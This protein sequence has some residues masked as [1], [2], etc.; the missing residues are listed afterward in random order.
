MK[1]QRSLPQS[2]CLSDASTVRNSPSE[3]PS[4][5][6]KMSFGGCLF[7]CTNT[8][9]SSYQ[10][11]LVR[12]QWTS[13]YC[14]YEWD[15]LN[16]ASYSS[17]ISTL[18]D[19]TL[20]EATYRHAFS[21]KDAT[22][23]ATEGI[24]LPGPG[25]LTSAPVRLRISMIWRAVFSPLPITM[26][27]CMAASLKTGDSTWKFSPPILG[28]ILSDWIRLLL[29]RWNKTY[30]RIRLFWYWLSRLWPTLFLRLLL[31]RYMTRKLWSHSRV[32][33]ITYNTLRG[34]PLCYVSEPLDLAILL[35]CW[36]WKYSKYKCGIVLPH[37][38]SQLLE[39]ITK[40]LRIFSARASFNLLSRC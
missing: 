39:S 11:I 12:T 25:W 3:T 10:D 31:Q 23:E 1:T 28:L 22:R 35:F 5:K 21:S 20:T 9:R 14:D 7:L 24:W 29:A 37:Q 40:I 15:T 4:L 36:I 38:I 2:A 17:M 27:S 16:I 8:S 13:S 6:I 18:D 33:M 32:L 26:K 19:W 34:N 30:L